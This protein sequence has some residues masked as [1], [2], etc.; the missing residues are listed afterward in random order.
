MM[1]GQGKAV[2][3]PGCPHPQ[4]SQGQLQGNG[5]EGGFVGQGSSI[6]LSD[7]GPEGGSVWFMAWAASAIAL[8]AWPLPATVELLL[9]LQRSF[10]QAR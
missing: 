8:Q 1:P 2:C 9:F 5:F 10:S 4:P 3:S 6:L 7:V